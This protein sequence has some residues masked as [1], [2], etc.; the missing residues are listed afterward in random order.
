MPSPLSI[1]PSLD[2]LLLEPAPSPTKSNQFFRMGRWISREWKQTIEETLKDLRSRQTWRPFL[3]YLY[4]IWIAV[5]LVAIGSLTSSPDV[6]SLYSSAVETACQP[7]GSFSPYADN[8][9]AWN[10]ASSGFFEIT[11]VF[12]TLSFTVA[13]VID[14][15]WDVVSHRTARTRFELTSIERVLFRLLAGWDNL[16]SL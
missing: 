13:K 10:W 6:T 8:Y 5:L 14:I 4:L 1:H 2:P 12:G 3:F 15:C 9:N 7:D 16:P 11:L